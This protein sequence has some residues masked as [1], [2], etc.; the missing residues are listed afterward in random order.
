MHKTHIWVH[1]DEIITKEHQ[2]KIKIIIVNLM[3]IQGTL[4][5]IETEAVL[6]KIKIK[7]L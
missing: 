2:N 3:C 7:Y 5:M 4:K 1:S 6:I